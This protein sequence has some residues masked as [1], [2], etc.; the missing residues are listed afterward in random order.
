[1]II[2]TISAKAYTIKKKKKNSTKSE[3]FF[4]DSTVRGYTYT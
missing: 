4:R 3:K 1:M 2:M